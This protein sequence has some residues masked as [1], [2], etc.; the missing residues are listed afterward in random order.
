MLPP[1]QLGGRFPANQLPVVGQRRQL[2]GFIRQRQADPRQAEGLPRAG[3]KHLQQRPDQLLMD[4]QH[5]TIAIGLGNKS[6]RYRGR[7]YHKQRRLHRIAMVI[8]LQLN[9]SGIKVVH[10]EIAVVAMRLHVAAK[11]GRHAGER[12]VVHLFGTQTL[13]VIFIDVDVGDGM[14]AHTRSLVAFLRR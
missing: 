9:L 13:V 8:K 11:K 14:L 12:L 7:R 1:R 6:V 3:I 5:M 4:R 2:V 10:L